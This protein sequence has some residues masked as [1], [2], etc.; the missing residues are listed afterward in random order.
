MIFSKILPYEDI[1]KQLS[2]EAKI[3]IISCNGCARISGS[4]GLGKADELR[5]RLI[6]GG[7]KVTDEVVV[8]YACSELSLREAKQEA[9]LNPDVDTIIS[10]ACSAGWS[11]ITRNFTNKRVINATEDVGLMV[12]DA[13]N[14][15]FKL[16]M[17]YK[18]YE[19][20]AGSE[21]EIGTGE[22]CLEKKIKLEV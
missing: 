19:K 10:L 9:K 16:T 8:L 12:I 1:I 13:D 14:G 3:A 6:R 4:G 18:R 5:L 7:Y 11:C 20:Q 22:F 15:V 2:K 17:P 21:Y